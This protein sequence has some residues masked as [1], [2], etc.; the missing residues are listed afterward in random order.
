MK[1]KYK[2]IYSP[3]MRIR[4]CYEYLSG[5]MKAQDVA[6]KYRISKRTLEYWLN[7]YKNDYEGIIDFYKFIMGDLAANGFR[8]AAEYMRD[9]AVEILTD[10]L[11]AK[12]PQ[13]IKIDFDDVLRDDVPTGSGDDISDSL[14]IL[15]RINSG[16]RYPE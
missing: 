9:Y 3:T 13:S 10:M 16:S 6:D 11:G 1:R 12:P 14:E 7:D 4:I 5:Q 8:R 15:N 2:R